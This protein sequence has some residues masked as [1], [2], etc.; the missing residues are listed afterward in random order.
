MNA[1]TLPADAARDLAEQGFTTL[2]LLEGEALDRLRRSI[3][4]LRAEAAQ[5]APGVHSSFDHPD[6]ALRAKVKAA[7]GPQLEAGLGGH[8]GNFRAI[9]ASFIAKPPGG[10]MLDVH[11]DWTLTLDPN[12]ASYTVW[13]PLVDV[14]EA[15]G[16]LA[17]VPGTHRVQHICGPQLQGY[18]GGSEAALRAASV[19]PRLK[20]GQAV[21]FDNRLLHWSHPNPGRQD[22]PAATMSIIPAGSAP[23][24]FVGNWQTGEVDVV[25]MGPDGFVAE[26]FVGCFAGA[27]GRPRLAPIANPNR[28]FPLEAIL[29]PRP[30]PPL[31]ERALRLQVHGLAK[32]YCADTRRAARYALADTLGE[33]LPR[34]GSRGLRVGEFLA[35]DGI[36]LTL[37]AGEAVAVLGENGS[38]KSTLLKIVNGLIK[39]SAGEVRRRGSVGAIIEL[40]TGLSPALTG[41]ENIALGAA[42]VGLRGKDAARLAEETIAFAELEEAIDAPF[43]TYSTGMK[44]RL[45]YALATRLRPDVLLVDEALAVGDMHFQRKCIADMR[46]YVRRGG[47]LLLVSHNTYHVQSVCERGLLLE[48]GRAVFEGGVAEALAAMFE[49]R[50]QPSE[51]GN[52]PHAGASGPVSIDRVAIEPV[53][54]ERIECGGAVRVCLSYTA[55][56]QVEAW[57]GFTL[58]TSD[59]AICITSSHDMRDRVLE[60]GQGELVAVVPSLSLV[61]G[62][63]RISAVL[64]DARN[65]QPY[66]QRGWDDHPQFFD[67]AGA[68]RIELNAAV[69]VGQLTTIAVDWQ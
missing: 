51:R 39:P 18:W 25:D 15:S 57:W 55:R 43:Q 53:E 46:D 61:P 56:E 65:R 36:D 12:E 67:V 40:G 1:I 30:A 26:G 8:F 21:V 7:I 27:P 9:I 68:A 10:A 62:R 13:C 31:G 35:L 28:P 14:D 16:G 42:M 19:T 2:V 49:R 45:A 11:R 41:R 5:L 60:P 17:L 66:A 59:Q 37:R 48:R 29:A 50:H 69:H 23:G 47:A 54:G 34:V 22:R 38:G 52:L 63:Y 20:A 58:L 32:K 24:L 64:I 33:V 4:G 44:A 6:A 3:A